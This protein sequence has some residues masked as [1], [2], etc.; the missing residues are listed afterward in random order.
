MREFGFEPFIC[1][2]FQGPI[3]TT[4]LYPQGRTFDFRHMHAWLKEHGYVIYPGKLTDR[5]TFRIGNIGEIYADDAEKILALF[6][7]YVT[8]FVR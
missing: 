8:E 1:E 4:F 3:I 5:D 6:K 7:E 2:E